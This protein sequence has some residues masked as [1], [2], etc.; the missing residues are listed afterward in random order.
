MVRNSFTSLE[1]RPLFCCNVT[2]S[3][4]VILQQKIISLKWS[5]KENLYAKSKEA[6]HQPYRSCKDQKNK[7]WDCLWKEGAITTPQWLLFKLQMTQGN[8]E[9]GNYLGW[10]KNYWLL[11]TYFFCF[12]H[13]CA[14]FSYSLAD[15]ASAESPLSLLSS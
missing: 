3:V 5:N 11:P 7:S 14:S 2:S 4:N 1:L 8:L 12:K 13:K 6:I 9:T 10:S 15:R